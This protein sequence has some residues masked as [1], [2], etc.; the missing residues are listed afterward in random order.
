VTRAKVCKTTT[1][2][3][4]KIT[5]VVDGATSEDHGLGAGKCAQC[6]DDTPSDAP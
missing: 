3:P 1:T 2:A 4:Q 6:E 5:S